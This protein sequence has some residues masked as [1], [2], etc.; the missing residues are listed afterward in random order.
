MNDRDQI[1]ALIFGYADLIDSG[2]FDG[3][4]RLFE[5]AELSFAGF[6]ER[7]RGHEQV[8]ALYEGTTRRYED[9]TPKSKHV[10]TNVVVDIDQAAGTAT[11]R[12]YFTVLQAV[13]GALALQPVI[14]GRYRDEF[15][16]V[17]D[18]W[19]FSVRHMLIDL[20][21]DLSHHL[22]MELNP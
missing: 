20:A 16:R 8:R 2:D 11:A 21:G 5:H 10:V 1:D 14:A 7:R 15:V 12:S 13:P 17:G 19:R 6:D 9:G 22:R 18:R 4:G 3:L